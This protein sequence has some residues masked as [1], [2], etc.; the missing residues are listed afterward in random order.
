MNN[1]SR[2]FAANHQSS[3]VLRHVVRALEVDVDD[4]VELLR[5]AFQK[6]RH[7]R[8]ASECRVILHLCVYDL[9]RIG[10]VLE[11]ALQN[12]NELLDGCRIGDVHLHPER[13]ARSPSIEGMLFE[14][15]D[16]RENQAGAARIED[17]RDP[18][19]NARST[20]CNQSNAI[21]EAQNVRSQV[22]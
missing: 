6:G 17:A 5:A 18:Q 15:L 20:P 19:A 13:L 9:D 4:A 2:D 14:G 21:V 11:E 10:Q 8:D 1:G 7:G 16:L 3:G 22:G 12:G